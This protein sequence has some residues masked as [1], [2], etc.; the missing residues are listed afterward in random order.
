MVAL[1][2]TIPSLQR[3][4]V[5]VALETKTS[6][7]E[8]SAEYSHTTIFSSVVSV[9]RSLRPRRWREAITRMAP[10]NVQQSILSPSVKCM[11]YLTLPIKQALCPNLF[12]S[13]PDHARSQFSSGNKNSTRLA[14]L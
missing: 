6:A 2:A 13:Q 12:P 11:A 3:I 7:M 10:S 8:V 4:V 14:T 9:I 1:L 5:A